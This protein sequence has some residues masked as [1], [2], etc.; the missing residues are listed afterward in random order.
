MNGVFKQSP[1]DFEVEELPAYLPSGEG[2]HLF[3]WVEKRGVSTPDAAKRLTRQLGL[4]ERDISWAGLK[5]KLA[6]TRQFFSVTS[7]VE[8]LVGS[9]E[10]P[11]VKILSAKKHK[12]KLKT[13]HLGGNRFTL[14]VRSVTDPAAFRAAYDGLVANGVPNFFGEQRFG[15]DNAAQGKQLLLR[16]GKGGGNRFERKLLLSSYQ[17]LLFNRALERR[18]A[19]GTLARALLG[20]VLKKHETGGEFVCADPG[21]DQPRVEAFEVSPTGPM[22]GPKM[23]RAEG[24]VGALEQGLLD[25]EKIGLEVFDAGGGETLGTRRLF[26]VRLGEPSLSLEGDVAKLAFT[27]PSGSYATVVLGE[28]TR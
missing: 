14:H 7:K 17:S 22:F 10:D 11:D 12:N 18:I 3:L 20:D 2:E 26:R 28:L 8:G 19:A 13:G 16:G 24:E 4:S 21:V 1:E 25:E 23:R 27:L 9:F 6:V 5:D 15:A